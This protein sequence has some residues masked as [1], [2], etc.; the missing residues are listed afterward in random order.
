[1]PIPELVLYRDGKLNM[2]LLDKDALKWA[3]YLQK[4]SKDDTTR[5]KLR[6]YYDEFVNLENLAKENRLKSDS[7]SNISDEI[8]LQLQMQK[9][10][11]AYDAARDSRKNRKIEEFVKLVTDQILAQERKYDALILASQFF[12]S[13]YAYFYSLTKNRD[14][15]QN[16]NVNRTP[17]N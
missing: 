16:N 12:E 2:D 11:A 13:V 4:S 6:K 5:T 14:K 1:V 9:A 10:Y 17:A 15:S 3:E 8:L 7:T